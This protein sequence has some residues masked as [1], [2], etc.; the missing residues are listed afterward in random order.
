[1]MDDSKEPE[2]EDAL[3]TSFESSTYTLYTRRWFILA[4]LS[5][6]SASNSLVCRL[7]QYS[8]LL[9]TEELVGIKHC[10]VVSKLHVA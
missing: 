4:I 3:S 8:H 5:L 2:L 6:L 10:V 9:G 1:M 7:L